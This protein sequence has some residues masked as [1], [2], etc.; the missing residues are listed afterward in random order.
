MLFRSDSGQIELSDNQ[1]RSLEI[2][3]RI[4][5]IVFV[6]GVVKPGYKE[7][8][9]LRLTPNTDFGAWCVQEALG[10][11]DPDRTLLTYIFRGFG[12]IMDGREQLQLK[13]IR[14]VIAPDP[15][16]IPDSEDNQ[17]VPNLVL[18]VHNRLS[19]TSNAFAK[20]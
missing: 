15:V 19:Q 11:S 17:T 9:P 16:I 20:N 18:S 1:L 8:P 4:Y 12:W 2:V 13:I 5:Q 6:E 3:Q 7:E 10:I 14:P